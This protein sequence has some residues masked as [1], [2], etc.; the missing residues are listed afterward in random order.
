MA[1]DGNMNAHVATY[2]RVIA[3]LKWG[4]IAVAI[5]AFAVIWLIHK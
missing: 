5:I 4:G 1:S 3:M 2:D